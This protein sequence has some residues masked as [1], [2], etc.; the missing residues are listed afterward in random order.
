VEDG[1]MHLGRLNVIEMM[2]GDRL[3][4]DVL[5]VICG[6]DGKKYW[7]KVQVEGLASKLRYF[8]FPMQCGGN[9]AGELKIKLKL[10]PIPP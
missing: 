1:V 5:V 3:D 8:S 4:G 9:L 6:G 7:T 10:V 2:V